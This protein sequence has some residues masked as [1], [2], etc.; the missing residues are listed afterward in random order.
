MRRYLPKCTLRRAELLHE[1]DDQGLHEE[2]SGGQ[3]APSCSGK[4]R[5]SAGRKDTTIQQGI[6]FLVKNVVFSTF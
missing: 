6:K 1:R 2:G 3:S 4:K 5:I